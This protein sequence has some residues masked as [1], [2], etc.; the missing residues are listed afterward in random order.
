MRRV[1]VIGSPGA[2]K[3]VWARALSDRTGL[4]IHHLD[5]MHWLSGWRERDPA[6]ERR[7]LNEVLAQPAWIID[8]NYG[9]TL[10]LRIARADTVVWLDYPAVLCLGRVIKRWWQFRGMTRADMT[11]DCNERLSPAFLLYVAR[12]RRA[13]RSRNHAALAN[14][15]GTIITLHG[16][17]QADRWIE[18]L[19]LPGA[20]RQS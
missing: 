18:S 12:F 1:L 6:D 3:S 14:F 20:T 11:E 9:S 13:W 4:P 16:P 7:L 5:Q 8:G 10:P 17:D 19:P 15:S 2:G